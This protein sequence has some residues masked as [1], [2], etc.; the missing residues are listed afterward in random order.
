MNLFSEALAWLAVADHWT[1]AGGI[2][3]R[4]LQH[5]AITAVAVG[6]AA[7]VALPAGIA[8]GHTG[9]GSAVVGALTGAARAVPTLGMLTLVGLWLGIG[10]AA[11]MVALVVLALPSIL[12]GAYAGVQSVDPATVDAA[13]AQGMNPTQVI[14]GVELP[15]AAPVLIGGLRAATLQVVATATLAAY[16][17]DF[18]LGRYLFAGLKS[19]DY[20]QM[21]GG[22]ILVTALAL[23]LELAFAGLQRATARTTR[24]QHTPSAHTKHTNPTREPS[25]RTSTRRKGKSP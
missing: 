7:L 14:T 13:R 21:L 15:L 1:G 12:A 23:T 20:P 6:A 16:V 19:R 3:T 2:T 4:L 9:K 5:V 24:P 18:G 22:A 8:I 10:L 25:T 11:P 17:S